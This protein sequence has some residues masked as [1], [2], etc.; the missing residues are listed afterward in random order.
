MMSCVGSFDTDTNTSGLKI[1][2]RLMG[3]R[4]WWNVG[5]RLSFMSEHEI[6]H[7][8]VLFSVLVFS[9]LWILTKFLI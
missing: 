7:Q 6:V 9:H 3:Y 4:L 1:Q 2:E 5:V 8:K